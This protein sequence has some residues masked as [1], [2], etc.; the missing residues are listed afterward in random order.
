[1]IL[2]QECITMHGH[3]KVKLTNYCSYWLQ[4]LIS[5]VHKY[6]EATHSLLI[7]H[8]VALLL[9]SYWF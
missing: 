8:F 3:L 7:K 4:N 1:L 9:A 5:L 2:L 6:V